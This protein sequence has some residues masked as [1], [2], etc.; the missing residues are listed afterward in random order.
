MA[1]A[2]L[3]L[4]SSIHI[5][6]INVHQKVS[7]TVTKLNYFLQRNETIKNNRILKVNQNI[8]INYDL[9]KIISARSA[10]FFFQRIDKNTKE[11]TFLY[12]FENYLVKY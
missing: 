11:F 3:I 12:E 1:L 7:K 9:T 2:L 5:K 10:L 8:S 6:T 4:T